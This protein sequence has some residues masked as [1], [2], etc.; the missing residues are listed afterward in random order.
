M[1]RVL[2][3]LVGFGLTLGLLL[4]AGGEVGAQD[5]AVSRRVR[6]ARPNDALHVFLAAQKRKARKAAPRKTD[7]AEPANMPA[8]A[9]A[10][11]PAAAP[12]ARDDGGLKFS[13][14]IAPILV[15]NCFRCHNAEQRKGKFDMTT[16]E[17]LMKGA[18]TERVID[19]G[20][21][22]DSHLVLRLRGE[23][24]PKMPPPQGQRRFSENAI[25]RIEEWIKQGATLD[26]GRDPKAP[27]TSYASTAQELQLA[28]F[29]K[30]SPE[31]RDEYVKKTGLED[32]NRAS[33]DKPEIAMSKNFVLFSTLPKARVDATLKTMEAQIAKLKG[34]LG[35]LGF[36][37][38]MKTTLYVFTDR[39]GFVEFARSVE[40]REVEEEDEASANFDRIAPYVAVAD[41]LHG[42]EEAAAA[43]KRRGRAKKD[44]DGSEAS[45]TLPGVLT[46]QLVSG[47]VARGGK[48]PKWLAL[49]LGAYAASS[50]ERGGPYI[51]SLRRT[52]YGL[53]EQGWSSKAQEA[54][55]GEAKTEDQRAVGFAVMDWLG[56]SYAAGLPRF[57][58]ALRDGGREKLD[59]AITSAFGA[60]REQ[61][62]TGSSEYVMSAYGRGR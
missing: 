18:D 6:R 31:Q 53:C 36:D 45:R 5:G 33:K 41:P 3:G 58:R 34:L 24:K 40:N 10:E 27:I 46:E 2:L 43:P 9:P 54:F 57:V 38:L 16:F 61:L 56:G 44:D 11:K 25:T 20:K 17:K 7:A 8:D 14:D 12:A 21:P 50:L 35:P 52:A 13:R 15:D 26:S 30:M 59:D 42:R 28:E 22:D 47:V 48:A 51:A 39:K 32:W 1:S 19:P 23:E 49:G 55:G 62:L 37:T 60:S 29:R 4:S